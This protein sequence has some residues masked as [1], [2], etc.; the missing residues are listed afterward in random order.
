MDSK[1][2]IFTIRCVFALLP[3]AWATYFLAMLRTSGWGPET[4]IVWAPLGIALVYAGIPA[5]VPFLGLPWRA[6]VGGAFGI[7]LTAVAVSEVFGRAQEMQVMR[8]YG[9][10]PSRNLAI[11]RWWPF[12]HHDIYYTPGSGWSGCD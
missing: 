12:E 2:E 1:R 11:R 9:E 4:S 6:V 8:E 10:T 5:A 7:C 3:L